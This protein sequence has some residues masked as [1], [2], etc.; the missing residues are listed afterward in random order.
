MKNIFRFLIP[1]IVMFVFGSLSTGKAEATSGESLDLKNQQVRIS[2]TNNQTG[3]VTYLQA[4]DVVSTITSVQSTSTG[5]TVGYDVYVPI[6]KID[7][8]II[9]PL[10]TDG[11]TKTEGGVKAQ[12]SVNYDVSSDNER[13]RLNKVYGG[14]YPTHSMYSVTS[15]KVNA[16]SGAMTGKTLKRTPDKNTF[17]YTTGWGYNDRV[18]G[19]AAPRAWSSAVIRI[20][21]MSATHTIK[22]EFTYS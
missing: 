2:I 9:T 1:V 12:L 8:S 19:E 14:W 6:S 11:R 21:G 5:K 22:V 20:S 13:V 10:D 7:P 3:E 15:R 4:E 17:S 16:H 18:W